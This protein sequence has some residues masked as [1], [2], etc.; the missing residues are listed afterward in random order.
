MKIRIWGCRGSIPT[1]GQNTVR[2][3]GNT[4]CVEINDSNNIIIVD[5]GTGIRRLGEDLINRQ[6]NDINLIISHSHWDHIQGFP[7]F[8][9]I[10]SD[11]TNINIYG[12]S[13]GSYKRFEDI[14]KQQMTYEYFP[15]SFL[16]LEANIKFHN[17]DETLQIGNLNISTIKNNHP[18]Q[19]N[20]FKFKYN[21]ENY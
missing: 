19:T 3:G 14:F 15:I 8:A 12:S 18:I 5:A 4:T 20:G 10:Y 13:S 6:I 1:P 2:Y 7:F 16:E 17:I 21:N 11:K 9:P